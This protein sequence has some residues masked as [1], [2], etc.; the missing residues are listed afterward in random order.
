MKKYDW[1]TIQIW[2]GSDDRTKLVCCDSPHQYTQKDI[3]EALA[4]FRQTNGMG[5]WFFDFDG[6]KHEDPADA[7]TWGPKSPNEINWAGFPVFKDGEWV[8]SE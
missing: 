8:L 7:S 2:N 6:R 3:I 1:Q 4:E 5:G